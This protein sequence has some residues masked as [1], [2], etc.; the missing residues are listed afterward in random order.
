MPM[1]RKR[2]PAN[3]EVISRRVRFERAGNKCEWCGV[4]NGAVG[5][6]DV[7]GKWWHERE[8]DQM[9]SDVG[10]ALFAGE[11]PKIIRIVL[12]VAHLGTPHANGTPGDKHDKMDVREENLAAL[13]QKCHLNY[14]REDHVQ[15]RR[16]N[17]RQRKA[18]EQHQHDQ[19]RG[20]LR[21]FD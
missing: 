9:K 3:W 14:D 16:D 1:D 21:M 13:C 18:S 5:A 20:Q 7:D 12:T 6:R 2:Y 4:E 11:Y 17:L 8:I 15:H 10:Y 19:E